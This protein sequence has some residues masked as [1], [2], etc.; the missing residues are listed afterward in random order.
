MNQENQNQNKSH[1]KAGLIILAI[2]IVIIAIFL[3][4]YMQA[5]DEQ[6]KMIDKGCE[7]EAFNQ[8]GLVTLWNCPSFMS[9]EGQ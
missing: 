5:R 2:T 4:H 6:Q 1:S 8:F 9:E 3:V 7:A